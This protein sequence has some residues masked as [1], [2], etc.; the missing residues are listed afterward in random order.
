[1]TTSLDWTRASIPRNGIGTTPSLRLNSAFWAAIPVWLGGLGPIVLFL[2]FGWRM[3]VESLSTS[4]LIGGVLSTAWLA[5]VPGI[6]AQHELFHAR[7][8]LARTVGRYAQFTL[9]DWR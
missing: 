2:A 9:L 7:D 6:A 4:Q 5:L 3:S 8:P 1:M